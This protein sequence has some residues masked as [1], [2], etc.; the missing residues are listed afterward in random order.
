MKKQR[1]YPQGAIKGGAGIRALIQQAR[2]TGE[3]IP[4]WHYDSSDG[5]YF[6]RYI[7]AKSFVDEHGLNYFD[8]DGE[9]YRTGMGT[10][11]GNDGWYL[12]TNYWFV[13]AHALREGWQL[14]EYDFA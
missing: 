1:N 13:F 9:R 11:T 10:L 4:I 2:A 7:T 12:Y 6:F 5:T 14:K 3:K 8:R